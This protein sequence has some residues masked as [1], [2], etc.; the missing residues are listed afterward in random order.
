MMNSLA[1][2]IILHAKDCFLGIHRTNESRIRDDNAEGFEEGH[3]KLILPNN[4]K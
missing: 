2:F 1:I 3:R 4:I